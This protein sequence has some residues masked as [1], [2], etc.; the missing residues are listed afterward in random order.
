MSAEKTPEVI[1]RER[2][3]ERA[4]AMAQ[5]V[6]SAFSAKLKD[7]TRRH[8][9]F[10]GLRHIDQ[11]DAEFQAKADHLSQIFEHAFQDV[12]REQEEL[13]WYSIKR[14]A[15][16]RL[17]VKRFEDALIRRNGN[18]QEKGVLSRCMLPG[19]FL[20]LN[21]MLGPEAMA[22]FQQRC[23]TAKRRLMA[24][25]TREDWD[26]LNQDAEVH[27]VMLDAEYAIAL[28]FENTPH[29]KKWFTTIINANLA[30]TTNDQDLETPWQLS[31]PAM[32]VL[33]NMLLGDLKQAV[34]DDV[35]WRHLAERHLGAD[36]H[37]LEF[38]LDRLE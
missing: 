27:D 34:A 10:L 26:L 16:D 35:A 28:H 23:E 32:H 8:G 20:A 14:P 21:M 38:I 17:I 25:H 33:I 36:R 19:F 7:E 4:N 29:R 9:G 15:F 12:Q 30:P 18:G 13:R 31:H 24:G 2:A 3:R 5:A 6:V 1:S 37:L 22:D 11:L